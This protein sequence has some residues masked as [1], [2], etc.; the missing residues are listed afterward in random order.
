MSGG[1]VSPSME[2]L[3]GARALREDSFRTFLSLGESDE[4][5][6]VVQGGSDVWLHVYHCDAVSGFLN[7]AVLDRSEVGIFHAGVEVYGEEWSF[8]YYEDTWE[9]PTVPGVVRC[10]PRRMPNYEYVE[11]LYM[12]RTETPQ[13]EVDTLILELH[14]SWPASS[15]HLTRRNCLTFA[16]ELTR[17]L[18]VPRPFPSKLKGILET[19][20]QNQS[21]GAAVDAAWSAL[22]WWMIVKNP[23][24]EPVVASLPEVQEL[25]PPSC[26]SASA[27]WVWPFSA[28]SAATTCMAGKTPLCTAVSLR[29]DAGPSGE[30]VR[31]QVVEHLPQDAVIAPVT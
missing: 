17:L 15:Y 27:G 25:S 16:E 22:K 6:E 3:L 10:T 2:M 26:G 24:P 31:R 23:K 5:R 11:S 12:G 21:V 18:D 30:G 4:V 19:S 28:C 8:Q 14:D 20:L 7:R 9:D 29:R 13:D 1:P